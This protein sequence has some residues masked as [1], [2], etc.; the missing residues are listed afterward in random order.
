M[1]EDQKIKEL[2]IGETLLK[3]RTKRGISIKDVEKDIK[4]RSKY[5]TAIEND[6]YKQIPGHAY[7]LGF[8]KNYADYLEVETEALIER[9]KEEN[10]DPSKQSSAF[11]IGDDNSKDI[12]RSRRYLFLIVF[13]AIFTLIVFIVRSGRL[14]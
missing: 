12:K 14:F 9:F 8:I 5:L 10:E 4:I 13:I 3:E 7:V 6:D 2:S 11:M 1:T